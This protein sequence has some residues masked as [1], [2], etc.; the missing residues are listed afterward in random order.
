[1]L[2]WLTGLEIADLL[3]KNSLSWM[4]NEGALGE[5]VDVCDGNELAFGFYARYGSCPGKRF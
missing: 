4:G 2:M 5:I 1:M 3:I